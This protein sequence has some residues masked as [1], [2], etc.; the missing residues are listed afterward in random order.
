MIAPVHR[1]VGAIDVLKAS[2]VGHYA[3]VLRAVAWLDE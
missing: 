1:K 2:P 3:C